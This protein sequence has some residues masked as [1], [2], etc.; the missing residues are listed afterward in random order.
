MRDEHVD[1]GLRRGVQAVAQG[2]GDRRVE[3]EHR[4]L[5]VD[6]LIARPRPRAAGAHRSAG[7]RRRSGGAE[8]RA[9][10]RMRQRTS[11][12]VLRQLVLRRVE[13]DQHERPAEEHDGAVGVAVA[14]ADQAERAALEEA[15]VGAREPL[16]RLRRP[17]PRA[18]RPPGSSAPPP[19]PSVA[20]PSSSIVGAPSGSTMRTSAGSCVRRETMK[21]Q[22][23]ASA[24]TSAISSG[25]AEGCCQLPRSAAPSRGRAAGDAP[26][27]SAR[28]CGR[29][30]G[31]ARR[32]GRSGRAGRAG[33]AAPRRVASRWERA[34]GP[35]ARASRR[36][37]SR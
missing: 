34:P 26:S 10:L 13:A 2:V 1:R 5:D 27:C 37:R 20:A 11:A 23:A 25:I 32:A 3:A 9:P 22:I 35:C 18:P 36:R 24:A 19:A 31:D 14:H 12:A 16:E 6:R 17:Q 33:R 4:D 7:S 15:P 28:W 8:T 29:A 30:A 21:T